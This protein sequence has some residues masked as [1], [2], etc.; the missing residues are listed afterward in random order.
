MCVCEG[1][2]VLG[3]ESEGRVSQIP[4]EGDYLLTLHGRKY[5]SK[6]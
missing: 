4:T 5:G 6:C 2:G 3:L 1:G